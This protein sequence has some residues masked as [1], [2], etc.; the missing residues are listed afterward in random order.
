M[1]NLRLLS[2]IFFL[3]LNPRQAEKELISYMQINQLLAGPPAGRPR[4]HAIK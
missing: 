1:W 3:R 4:A 2:R